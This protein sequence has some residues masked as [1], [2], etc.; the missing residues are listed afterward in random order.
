MCA[1]LTPDTRF[2][3]LYA[4]F[5]VWSITLWTLQWN[6]SF[7]LEFV[8]YSTSGLIDALNTVVLSE[9]CVQTI[10]VPWFYLGA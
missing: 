6:F 8:W 1:L 4:S 2:F 7:A 5:L 3:Y 9:S 10:A